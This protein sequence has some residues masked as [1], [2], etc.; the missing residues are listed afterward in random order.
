MPNRTLSDEL[1]SVSIQKNVLS[2]IFAKEKNSNLEVDIVAASDEG[3][4][5]DSETES[6]DDISSKVAASTFPHSS[7][8]ISKYISSQRS[9]SL[10]DI[11]GSLPRPL[12]DFQDMFGSMEGSY[13]PDFPMSLRL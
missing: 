4:F 2:G 6:E 9:Q 8:S 13:P 12:K 5:T 1:F 3:S 11:G 10:D 7:S